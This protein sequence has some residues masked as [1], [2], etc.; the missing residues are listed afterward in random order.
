MHQRFTKWGLQAKNTVHVIWCWL[1]NH[2]NWNCHNLMKVPVWNTRNTDLSELCLSMV[3]NVNK[4]LKERKKKPTGISYRGAVFLPAIS[5]PHS[6]VPDCILG[7]SWQPG[8]LQG[9]CMQLFPDA[10]E[11]HVPINQTPPCWTPCMKEHVTYFY[12]EDALWCAKVI[13]TYWRPSRYEKQKSLFT[14]DEENIL[15]KNSSSPPP[16][17]SDCPVGIKIPPPG[18]RIQA[19]K[20]HKDRLGLLLSQWPSAPQTFMIQ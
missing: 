2:A 1:D 5:C 10:P 15:C 8:L 13:S 19:F 16:P 4:I 11:G 3:A 14:H 7:L 18:Y 20:M 17:H 6:P 9:M 12:K